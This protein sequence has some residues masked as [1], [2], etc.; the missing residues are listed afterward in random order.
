MVS[1]GLDASPGNL[2]FIFLF[3]FPFAFPSFLSTS[4]LYILCIWIYLCAYICVS[5]FG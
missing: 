3:H 2:F 4:L 1:V 5:V